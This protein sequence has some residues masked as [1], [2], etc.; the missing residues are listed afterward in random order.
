MA[1]PEPARPFS[2]KQLTN[3]KG[4]AKPDPL[5]IPGA[6]TN[7]A[8]GGDA[9]DAASPNGGGA[10]PSDDGASPSDDGASPSDGD[11]SARA[12]APALA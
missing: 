7:N 3:K 2:L 12:N 10:N 1:A 8:S 6:V 4:I 11:A 9:S 5:F